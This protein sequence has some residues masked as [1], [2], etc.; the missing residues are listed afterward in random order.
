VGPRAFAAR[1]VLSVQVMNA[2]FFGLKRARHGTLRFMRPLLTRLGLTAARFD[3]LYALPQ[4]TETWRGMRQS[5]LR[6]RLGVSRATVSRM[7]AS[8]EDL[9]VVQRERDRFDRRQKTVSL[10]QQG[11]DLIRRAKRIFI[12]GGLAQLSVDTALLAEL[13][14]VVTPNARHTKSRCLIEM[15]KLD[16]ALRKFRYTFGDFAKLRYPW[17]PD[18]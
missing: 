18:D 11:L 12:H 4:R 3:L 10:T 15:N 6:R 13:G 5:A 9:G 8:L 16:W 2:I 1:G 17:R 7:L 14:G